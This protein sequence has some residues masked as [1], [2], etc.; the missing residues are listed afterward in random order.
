MGNCEGEGAKLPDW[1]GQ[2]IRNLRSIKLGVGG[3]ERTRL[4]LI[5]AAAAA[6]SSSCAPPPPPP[7]HPLLSP[8]LIPRLP[9][10][11]FIRPSRTH[12]RNPFLHFKERRYGRRRDLLWILQGVWILTG[13]KRSEDSNEISTSFTKV[14][15]IFE[16]RPRNDGNR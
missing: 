4:S 14:C 2:P 16:Y 3:G 6:S 12:P 11:P 9:P 8:F 1:K 7:L 5:D 13:D 10:H 15:L